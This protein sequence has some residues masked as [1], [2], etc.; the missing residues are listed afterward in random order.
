MNYP[1]RV[2]IVGREQTGTDEDTGLPREREFDVCTLAP[3]AFAVLSAAETVQQFGD[4]NAT[5]VPTVTASLTMPSY[6]PELDHD[7]T[8]Y[9][10]RVAGWRGTWRIVSERPGRDWNTYQLTR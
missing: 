8:D 4:G 5:S 1:D 10:V 3:C 2:S 7:L 9:T 6:G